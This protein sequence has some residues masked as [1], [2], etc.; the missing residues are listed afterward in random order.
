MFNGE[1]LPL[2]CEVCKSQIVDS[3]SVFWS[4]DLRQQLDKAVRRPMVCIDCERMAA[5]FI[6][7]SL[8]WLL[9]YPSQLERD[10][11]SLQPP[12]L[13]GGSNP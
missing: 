3:V 10:R 12:R 4:S 2:F 11:D 1:Q 13:V 8:L 7:Y 5:T 6:V 9:V